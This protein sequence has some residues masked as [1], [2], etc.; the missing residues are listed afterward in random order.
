[1]AGGFQ[2]GSIVGALVLDKTKWTQ[3]VSGVKTDMKNMG[4]MSDKMAGRFKAAGTAMTIAGAAIV[5][6]LGSM[7]IKASEAEETYA[8]FGTVFQDVIGDAEIAAADLAESYGLS[9]LA[10]KD[11]LAATGDL[12]T[13]LGVNSEAALELS[14]KTQQLAVDLASFTNFSGGAK[15]ASE[16]LTKAML[17][18][19]ESIKSLG[20][21]ITE[22]M[23]KE[24]LLAEGKEK[25][26]GLA[27]KQAAAEVT[28]TIAMNQSKNAIGDYERTSTSF[29]NQSR[30]LKS[31]LEDVAVTLGTQ[32]LP[33]AT[34]MVTKITEV[35][36]KI[37]TW[38]AEHPKL[39]NTLVKVIAAL[40]SLML[41][42]GPFLIILPK[43]AAG[44][45]LLKSGLLKLT[46]PM[47]LVVAGLVLI[48]AKA[49]EAREEF[50][51]SMDLYQKEM[52]ATGEKISW[53]T[54]TWNS[55]ST[56][57]EK[58]TTGI[59]LNKIALQGYE[60]AQRRAN[61]IITIAKTASKG[62]SGAIS[63]LSTKFKD[64]T[65]KSTAAWK[66]WEIATGNAKTF[67]T[68]TK[69]L[70]TTIAKLPVTLG[71][72]KFQ[73][74]ALKIE[75]ANLLDV[76][77]QEVFGEAVEVIED[78]VIW[79]EMIQ[80]EAAET[81]GVMES[82]FTKIG[83]DWKGIMEGLPE[84]L[85]N[86]L[87]KVKDLWKET[88]NA[89]AE[90][91][92]TFING[93]DAAFDQAYKNTMIRIDNE[94][95]RRLEAINNMYDAQ[96]AAGEALVTAEEERTKEKMD[97]LDQWYEAEKQ[98]IL[99][100]ITDEEERKKALEKLD[101]KLARKREKLLKKREEKEQETAD[102]LE[103][104]EDAKNE[105]LRV[106]AEDLEGKRTDARRQGAKQE[107]AVALLSAIVATAAAIVNALKLPFPFNLIHAAVVGAMGAVQIALI[108]AKPI[109][110]AKGGVVTAPTHALI[111][112][113]GPELVIP[114]DK[115]QSIPQVRY[116][117]I[118]LQ[119]NIET[120]DSRDME[121]WL[122]AEGARMIEDI[123]RQNLGGNAE[124]IETDLARY[125]RY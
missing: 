28:L 94:E 29:A 117:D 125:R 61:G 63:F 73:A 100:N 71:M 118:T 86:P 17:G 87:K 95:K 114:L 106:A 90:I 104:I 53:F 93:I 54:R 97:A 72:T 64:V 101:R 6:A 16:A 124:R 113:A 77:D 31:R 119:F 70:N 25:L 4:G 27:Y 44:L 99:D 122:R 12:L 91:V 43:L 75:W 107:K 21:V 60:K 112:E 80:L 89:I 92:F 83:L 39:T 18:E 115:L 58:N 37:S 110:L 65:D 111:G 34:Q 69:T 57:I 46:S 40:G 123:L 42:L 49:I 74:R 102:A 41:V 26:T 59:D 109:P 15:G 116:G 82:V 56:V 67:T 20:I 50:K 32:L 33:I 23:V 9:T 81:G 35:V 48:T 52:D 38:T 76:L 85:K 3:S 19:R 121:R 78:G 79:L 47:G 10:S 120:G 22:E 108:K 1:M 30:L 51:K 2:A 45:K 36:Q 14:L 96:I 5:G 66:A 68:A 105:A 84:D 7:I 11:M 8:K 55:L 103:D 88:F 24:A 98:A 13:G 62:L